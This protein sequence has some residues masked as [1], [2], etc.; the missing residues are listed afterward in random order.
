MEV[1]KK[2]MIIDNVFDDEMLKKLTEV[3]EN[4]LKMD[5]LTHEHEIVNEEHR[6][7]CLRWYPP[8]GDFIAN[9]IENV[10]YGKEVFEKAFELE[11][12]SWS[13]FINN[14]APNFE[15]QVTK[16]SLNDK[17]DWHCDIN[18]RRVL[19]YIFWLKVPVEG[20]E[21]QISDQIPEG[22]ADTFGTREYNVYKTITPKVNRIVIVSSWLM[23]RVKPVISGERVTINGHV[24]L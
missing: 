15:V 9:T 14:M 12:Y 2:F 5:E 21:L 18:D 23:H 17:Y 22:P 20:G 8:V 6:K 19:N 13:V 24:S 7:Y 11:D 3:C 10:V 1:D 16:Y 4:K